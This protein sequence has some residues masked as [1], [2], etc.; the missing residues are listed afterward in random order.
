MYR[1]KIKVE[2][3]MCDY[4]G[5]V[6]SHW[7]TNEKLKIKLGNYTRKTFDRFTTADSCTS[8][9]TH[10]TESAAVCNWKREPWGSPL[11]QGKYE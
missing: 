4:T 6:W 10:N 5:Y 2:P 9:I 1:V 11:V 3:E 7:N 8:I